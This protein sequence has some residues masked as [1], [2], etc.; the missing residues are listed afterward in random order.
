MQRKETRTLIVRS[1]T[2]FVLLEEAP[3]L[4]MLTRYAVRDFPGG[5]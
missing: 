2:A 4:F 5:R 1:H 3:I